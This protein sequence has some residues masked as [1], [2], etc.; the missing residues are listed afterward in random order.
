METG[1]RGNEEPITG[2][3]LPRCH[4]C[5][6]VPEKGIKGGIKIRKSFICEK[7]ESHVISLQAGCS[8]YHVV[9]EQ[10]KGIW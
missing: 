5:Q 6:E 9:L 2:V 4:L 10:L 1:T 8:E 3:L 7:C